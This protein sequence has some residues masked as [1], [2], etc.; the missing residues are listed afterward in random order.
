MTPIKSLPPRGRWVAT[1][2][3]WVSQIPRPA[4]P[5]QKEAGSQVSRGPTSPDPSEDLESRPRSEIPRGQILEARADPASLPWGEDLAFLPLGLFTPVRPSALGGNSHP[6]FIYR[7]GF[8]PQ[9]RTGL[10]KR[11]G[12]CKFHRKQC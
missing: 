6:F 2:A 8:L 11:G 1:R 3:S 9:Q 4:P 7:A 10:C 12:V 5:P